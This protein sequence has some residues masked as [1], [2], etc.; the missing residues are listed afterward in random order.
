MPFLPHPHQP[1]PGRGTGCGQQSYPRCQD[2]TTSSE[3]RTHGAAQPGLKCGPETWPEDFSAVFKDSG[4]SLP[5]EGSQPHLLGREREEEEGLVS[6]AGSSESL[7]RGT[8]ESW[9]LTWL[10]RAE[11]GEP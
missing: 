4:F 5:A 3:G 11:A 1:W 2:T 8:Q 6:L 7:P 10:Q 9:D